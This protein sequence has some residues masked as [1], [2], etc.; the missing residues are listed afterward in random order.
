MKFGHELDSSSEMSNFSQ[1]QE[2]REPAPKEW[3]C[4]VQSGCKE[5]KELGVP[6]TYAGTTNPAD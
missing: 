4:A 3:A 5:I 6:P 1:D 2:N